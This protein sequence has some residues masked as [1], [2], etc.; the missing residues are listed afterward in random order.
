MPSEHP[1]GRPGTEPAPLT[2]LAISR[3]PPDLR[4]WR[5]DLDLQAPLPTSALALLDDAEQARLDR[6]HRHEDKA[7][8][9]L[10]RAALKRLLAGDDA[11]ASIR[12]DYTPAGRPVWRDANVHFNVAHSGALA[13]IALSERRAVGVDVEWRTEVDVDALSAIVL[14]PG[15]RATL[16]AC[17]AQA[18]RDAFYRYWVCK[19]AALKATG[20]GIAEALQRIE[21]LADDVDADTRGDASRDTRRDSRHETRRIRC[22]DAGMDD[23]RLLASLELRLLPLPAAY[24]GAVAWAS[25]DGAAAAGTGGG[26]S[27]KRPFSIFNRRS[28]TSK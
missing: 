12:F 10:T 27:D 4:L 7:R 22:V 15:E 9:A 3:A 19:E 2:R 18:R 5:L 14:T 25:R 28:A 16:Q 17:A 26:P 8:F 11:D 6:F 21:V 23:A 24:T 1:T 13:L 20:Q